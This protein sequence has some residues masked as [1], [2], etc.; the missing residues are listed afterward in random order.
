[1]PKLIVP[2]LHV[3]SR[4]I[5]IEYVFTILQLPYYIIVEGYEFYESKAFYFDTTADAPLYLFLDILSLIAIFIPPTLTLI[6]V[7]PLKEKIITEHT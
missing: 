2:Y 5:I 3:M 4:L 7:L 1:M 6:T